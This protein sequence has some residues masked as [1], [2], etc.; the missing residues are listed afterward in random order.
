MQS[1]K[2]N[3]EMKI[4]LP[5]RPRDA[6]K[7]NCGSVLVIAGST[8]MTGAGALASMAALRSG[9][10]MVTWAI[11]QSLNIIAETLCVEVLTLPLPET[12]CHAFSSSAR[13]SLVEAARECDA[14]VI[15]PGIV[16]V[17]ETAELI[18]MLI[19]EIPVPLIVDAG[20][21]RAI[22][23]DFKL[24]RRRKP[25]TIV[26]PHPGEMSDLCGLMTDKI[27]KDREK[28]AADYAQKSG[29]VVVLKGAGTVVSDDK[30][31]YVNTTG[32]P[33]MATAGAGDVLAGVIA[34]LTASKME[35]FDAAA[36]GVYLHGLAGDLAAEETGIHGLVAG[37]ILQ[38]IPTAFVTY[39]ESLQAR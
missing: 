10:G 21:I 23:R 12:H 36:L 15:G 18:H 34:A 2:K 24:L 27:Q 3:A 16:A 7:H 9:A 25:P 29:A 20:A 35:P 4:P 26:T 39:N 22:G 6:H 11:P 31:T 30:R 33:G 32:N 17:G 14:V 19:T 13:D 8:G 28:T 38:E 5:E 1:K 37:D